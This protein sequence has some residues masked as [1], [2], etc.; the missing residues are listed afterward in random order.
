MVRDGALETR[1]E[2]LSGK[3]EFHIEKRP[4]RPFIASVG[5]LEVRVIGTRFSTE[6]DTSQTPSIARVVVQEGVVEVRSSTRAP[7]RLT[8]GESLEV[9]VP[10]A[11][12]PVTP[13]QPRITRHPC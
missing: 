8:A 5:G 7:V 9:P 6:L 1:V 2:H 11:A 13:S 12:S 4:E 10:M 3:A